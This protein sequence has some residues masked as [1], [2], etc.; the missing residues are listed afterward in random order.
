MRA[1]PYMDS[2]LWIREEAGPDIKNPGAPFCEKSILCG[3]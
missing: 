1:S 2:A 3:P